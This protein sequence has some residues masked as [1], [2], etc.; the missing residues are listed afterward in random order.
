MKPVLFCLLALLTV[1]ALAAQPQ[2]DGVV[3]P[4]GSASQVLIPAAGSVAGGN[5]AFFR[6]D[7]SILNLTARR[8]T[9]SVRWLPQVGGVASTTTLDIPALS[10]IRS[11]DF[12]RDYMNQSGLGSILLTPVTDTGTFD[13][14]ARIN[15]TSRI[16]TIQP[17][18]T[19]STSQNFPGIPTSSINTLSASIFGMGGPDAPDRYRVNIGI[20]NLDTIEQEYVVSLLGIAVPVSYT[21]RIPGL[22]MQQIAIGS[23]QSPTQQYQVQNSSAVRST[24]WIAYGSTVDNVTG[25]AWSDLG[26]PG[27]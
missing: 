16:W 18:S 7:V 10:G 27:Q 15:V 24:N 20:V 4:V 14:T 17:G 8:V 1:P 6:S 3:I 2:P 13:G 26:I 22:S 25:D 19:G 21:V 23:G 12:V 5:G 11:S 9:L